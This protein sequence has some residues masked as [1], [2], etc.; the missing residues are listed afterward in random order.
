MLETVND[1]EKERLKK[2]TFEKEEKGKLYVTNGL[3]A[4]IKEKGEKATVYF[5]FYN[6]ARDEFYNQPIGVKTS[7]LSDK[8]ITKGAFVP[9][10][11]KFDEDYE[12]YEL[13]RIK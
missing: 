2:E 5:M 6:G 11:M 12:S 7:E 9:C 10:L 8:G 13:K 1:E 4:D 3:V